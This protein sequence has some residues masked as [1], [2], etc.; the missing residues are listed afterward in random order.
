GCHG[1]VCGVLREKLAGRLA[2]VGGT[3]RPPG[4]GTDPPPERDRRRLRD[5]ELAG[6]LPGGRGRRGPWCGRPLGGA[7]NAGGPGGESSC[8][9]SEKPPPAEAAVRPGSL[10][11]GRPA[12]PRAV[13]RYLR[14][15]PDPPRAGRPLLGRDPLSGRTRPRQRAVAGVLGQ[16]L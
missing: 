3:S 6:G 11:R 2:A 7:E 1:T 14:G 5:R 4:A 9:Q 16:A 8:L 12:P 15:L 10:P 13:R